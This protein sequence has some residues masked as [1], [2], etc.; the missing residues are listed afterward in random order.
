MIELTYNKPIQVNLFF[1]ADSDWYLKGSPWISVKKTPPVDK[2]ILL[3]YEDGGIETMDF[4]H[5]T[6]SH[7]LTKDGQV[8]DEHVIAWV[9][10]EFGI[11]Q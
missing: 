8:V 2:L 5:Y 10:V 1:H 4:G 11:K 3:Q 9:E 6:G 7:Y